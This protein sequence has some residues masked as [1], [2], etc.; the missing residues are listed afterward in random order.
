[1]AYL[2]LALFLV[3]FSLLARRLSSTFLSAPMAFMGFGVVSWWAGLVP[4][5]FSEEMLDVVAEI[6]LVL[7]LFLDAAQT[8]ARALRRDHGWPVRMLAFGLPLGFV[9]GTLFGWLMLPGWPLAVIALVAAI[10]V[11]TD[12]ALGQPVVSNPMVPE[13]SRRALTVESGLND[14]MALPLVLLMAALVAAET[15][16][17]GGGWL[18]FGL[19]QITLGPLAGVIV[20]CI[21]GWLLIRAKERGTTSEI[22]EGIAALALAVASYIL[23]QMIGGNGFIAAFAGGL[24]FGIVVRGRCEFVFEFTESEGQLLSW[25][26]FYLLG[27]VLVPEAIAGLTWPV[28]ALILVSLFVVRPLAIWVSL[29]GSDASPT[30]RLF[31]GWFGPRGLATALFALLVVDGQENGTAEM[32]QIVAINA[33]WISAVLHGITAVPG[34]IWYARRMRDQ[35][36][37][38]AHR[39]VAESARPLPRQSG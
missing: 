5:P 4:E 38:A 18:W 2:L 19:K 6:A 13:R 35:E 9:L 15:E 28:F 37:A 25:M 3:G 32:V 29:I 12:A 14:G 1:M 21:G 22:Y 33:V 34:A 8:D 27:A 36:D 23:A 10:L 20:G 7:L 17:P 39:P 16:A 30:T 11:P 24:G 26:A 31:F